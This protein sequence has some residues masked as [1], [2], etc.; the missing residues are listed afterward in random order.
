MTLYETFLTIPDKRNPS[1]LRYDLGL[2]LSIVLLATISGYIGAR[3]VE[4]FVSKNKQ[5]LRKYFQVTRKSLPSR[6]TI[7]KVIKSISF[8]DLMIAFS[9]WSNEYAAI[10]DKEWIAADGKAIRG[11]VVNPK[12]QYQNF[13]SMI[14]LFSHK[15]KQVITSK[16]VIGKKESELKSFQEMLEELEIENAIFTIDA[17]HCQKKTLSKIKESNNDYV[18]GVKTNQPKLLKAI[19]KT[20]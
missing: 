8:K 4:D 3:A 17:L 16:A 20:L 9:L 1:G 5:D 15:R 11:T 7:F 14:S 10:S 19:K 6:K 2:I 18:V 13:V 12:S